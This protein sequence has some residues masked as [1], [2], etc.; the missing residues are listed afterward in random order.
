M[1]RSETVASIIDKIIETLGFL[2]KTKKPT[3]APINDRH[4][5]EHYGKDMNEDWQ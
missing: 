1:G 4:R 5:A 3:P 2:E